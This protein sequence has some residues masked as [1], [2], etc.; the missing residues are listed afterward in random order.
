MFSPFEGTMGPLHG[1][2]K[3]C[4]NPVALPDKMHT[5]GRKISPIW[6]TI[7]LLDD[8][9]IAHS[10]TPVSLSRVRIVG[11][12]LNRLSQTA[13]QVFHWPQHGTEFS[14]LRLP[15][16]SASRIAGEFMTPR[17]IGHLLL[18]SPR[19]HKACDSSDQQCLA[20]G[21]PPEM[22]GRAP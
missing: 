22:P 11:G 7:A 17:A 18:V 4:R 6:R 1:R 13:V 2:Y 20:G 8:T 21:G 15:V 10:D 9:P 16:G 19:E 5:G 12:H 14:L 3:V